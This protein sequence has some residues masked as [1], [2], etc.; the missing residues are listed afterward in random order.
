MLCLPH[1]KLINLIKENVPTIY[2][3]THTHREKEQEEENG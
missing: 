1:I 2:T 3:T